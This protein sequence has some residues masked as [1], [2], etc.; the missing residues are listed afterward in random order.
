MYLSWAAQQSSIA[1][2]SRLFTKYAS[3]LV[4]GVQDVSS[5]LIIFYIWDNFLSGLLMKILVI[6]PDF[7]PNFNFKLFESI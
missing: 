1:L 7:F 3:D 5:F 6:Y 2:S 4:S